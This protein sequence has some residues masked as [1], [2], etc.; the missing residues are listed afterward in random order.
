MAPLRLSLAPFLFLTT[1]FFLDTELAKTT[2]HV[3]QYMV[4]VCVCV[5]VRVR[6][7]ACDQNPEIYDQNFS[8]YMVYVCLCLCVCM[9][10]IRGTHQRCYHSHAPVSTEGVQE[11][12]ITQS[13]IH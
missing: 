3:S 4:C 9:H 11:N 6:V 5:C 1:I 7:Y 13:C 2:C 10:K 8:K 12:I